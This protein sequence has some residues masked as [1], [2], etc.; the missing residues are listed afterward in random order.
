[1]PR[2]S[3]ASPQ[4][5]KKAE[6]RS[7]AV[8]RPEPKPVAKPAEAVKPRPEAK[9][10]AKPAEKPAPA[11]KEAPKPEQKKE[12]KPEEKFEE[13]LMTLSLRDAWNA[14]RT[15]RASA[16]VKVLKQQ[17]RRH[18]KKEGKVSLALNHAIWSRGMA[19]PPRTLKLKVRITKDAATAY[20]VE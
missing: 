9:P 20:P 16:A 19:K 14:P 6:T 1:M 2:G 5:E 4:E 13:R 11:K 12:A 10:E 17:L 15:K 3:E 18:T 7:E 8:A